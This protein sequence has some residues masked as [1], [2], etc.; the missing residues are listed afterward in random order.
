VHRSGFVDEFRPFEVGLAVSKSLSMWRQ[1][2]G[3]DFPVQFRCIC[4]TAETSWTSFR[5]YTTTEISYLIQGEPLGKN[6]FQFAAATGI[7]SGIDCSSLTRSEYVEQTSPD[8]IGIRYCDTV[9]MRIPTS[10]DCRKNP[11]GIVNYFR[12]RPN[13]VG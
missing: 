5:Q 3:S 12:L 13:R 4:L 11:V 10:P 9:N 7:L 8:S 2:T 6:H 1:Q